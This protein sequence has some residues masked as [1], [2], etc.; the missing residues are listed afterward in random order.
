MG[1]FVAVVAPRS[2]AVDTVYGGSIFAAITLHRSLSTTTTRF[3][4]CCSLRNHIDWH[5]IDWP[6]ARF[7]AVQARVAMH[8]PFANCLGCQLPSIAC[9]DAV[10]ARLEL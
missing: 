5:L 9:T 1:G 6:R 3:N 4:C 2:V 10:E 7:E 8:H